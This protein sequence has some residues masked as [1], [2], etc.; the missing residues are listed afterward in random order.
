MSGRSRFIHVESTSV[1]LDRQ[2][3]RVSLAVDDDAD[4]GCAHCVLGDV[5]QRLL[6]DPVKGRP[7][8]AGQGVQSDPHALEIDIYTKPLAP[9]DEIIIERLCQS[10]V[11]DRRRPKLPRD[12]V[13]ALAHRIKL[14]S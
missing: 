4:A 10:Q 3:Q 1:V 8:I 7:Y 5:G 14:R 12:M 11:V 2:T 13:E 6:A 9:V